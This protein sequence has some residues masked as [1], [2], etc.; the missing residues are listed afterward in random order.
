MLQISVH[1]I[2]N[3]SI[4]P[5]SQGWIYGANDDKGRDCNGDKPLINIMPNCIHP[6]RNRNIITCGYGKY[7]NSVLLQYVLNKWWLRKL[8]RKKLY[9]NAASN[10]ILQ[11]K[12]NY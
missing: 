4:L 5:V 2:H 9:H 1:E 3:D 8:K 7:I 6:T 11:K 12:P 10:R